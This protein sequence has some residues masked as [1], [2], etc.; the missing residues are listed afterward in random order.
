MNDLS[1]RL[2]PEILSYDRWRELFE[3]IDEYWQESLTKPIERL[4]NLRSVA[5]AGENDLPMI[6]DE[7]SAFFDK[8]KES[9]QPLGIFWKKNEINA[10]NSEVA[11]E[12]FL[13]HLNIAAKNIEFIPLY[14][15]K[16]EATYGR[17]FYTKDEL[18]AMGANLNDY[19]LSSHMTLRIN[20]NEVLKQGWSK[21]E[22][23]EVVKRYFEENVRP[24][25]IVFD[26]L[27]FYIV[28]DSQIYCTATVQSNR[29]TY[30]IAQ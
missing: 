9:S 26:G 12:A 28:D 20:R 11:V 10:K 29:I 17:E 14:A 23:D 18:T 4:K 21:E 27:N 30:C 13:Q 5:N 15:F 7:L 24:T 1:N 8:E 3:A 19:F 16:D 2:P 25:H 22:I 6:M